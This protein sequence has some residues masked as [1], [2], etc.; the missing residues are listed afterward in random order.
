MK[1]LIVIA[2]LSTSLFAAPAYQGKRTFKNS[3]HTSFVGSQKGD[4]HLNWIEDRNGNIIKYNRDTKNY[5]YAKIANTKRGSMKLVPSGEKVTTIKRAVSF[6]GGTGSDN[7]LKRAQ[8]IKTLKKN[9]TN[10]HEQG[11]FRKIR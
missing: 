7:H 4:E 11:M 1:N 10:S 5:E 2:L 3:D 8:L 6:A 9:K